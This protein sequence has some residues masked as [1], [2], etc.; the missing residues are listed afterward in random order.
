MDD[1]GS[2]MGLVR[3]MVWLNTLMGMVGVYFDVLF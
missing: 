3:D 2:V 1:N